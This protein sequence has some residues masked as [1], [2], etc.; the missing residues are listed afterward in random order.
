MKISIRRDPS[1]KWLGSAQF[2]VGKVTMS[3]GSL[4]ACG[5]HSSWTACAFALARNLVEA[6][7]EHPARLL[8][9][10]LADRARG[11]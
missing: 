5:M 9:M 11:T 7:L 10:H 6:I 3:V 8:D 4:R 1:G 2:N